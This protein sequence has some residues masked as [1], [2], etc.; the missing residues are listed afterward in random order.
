MAIHVCHVHDINSNNGIINSNN[1][2]NFLVGLNRRVIDLPPVDL[3]CIV[4]HRSTC[5]LRVD[6]YHMVSLLGMSYSHFS[7]QFVHKWSSDP[8]KYDRWLVKIGAKAP[9]DNMYDDRT[10]LLGIGRAGVGGR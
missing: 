4:D 7:S 3:H 9:W 6:I 1:G 5:I 8:R 10:S 2:T